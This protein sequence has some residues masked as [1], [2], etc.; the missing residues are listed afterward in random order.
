M[1]DT[2][3]QELNKQAKI[4]I[5]NINNGNVDDLTL[6]LINRLVNLYLYDSDEDPKMILT[7]K[8]FNCKNE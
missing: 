1:L 3:E 5:E 2:F 7:Q 6:N 4:C 8:L